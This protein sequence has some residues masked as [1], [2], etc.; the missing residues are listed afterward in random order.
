MFVSG[1]EAAAHSGRNQAQALELIDGYE[2]LRIHIG[3][4][5]REIRE[6]LDAARLE[7]AR[8]YLTGLDP[9][10]FERV[11][12]LTG[13]LGFERRDPRLAMERE[14]HVLSAT[15]ASIEADERYQQRELRVGADG[16]L[17]QKRIETTEMLQPWLDECQ[18]FEQHEGFLELIRVGY[19]TPGFSESWWQ[20]SYWKHWA[21]GDR[22]CK[23]LEMD[24][25]GDD[26]LPE[27]NKAAEQ[28][29]FWQSELD[30]IDRQI[31][32]IHDLVQRRDGAVARIPRLPELYLDQ[33]QQQLGEYLEEADLSLLEDWLRERAA[34]DHPIQAGLRKL[35]GLKAK[36]SFLAELVNQGLN[37]SIGQLRGRAQK[38][39]RK[40][41]K[42][43]RPKNYSRRFGDR[44]LDAK[45][46]AKAAKYQQRQAKLRSMVNRIYAYDDY[47]RFSLANDPALWWMEITGRQPPRLMPHTWRWYQRH[48]NLAPNLDPIDDDDDTLAHGVAVAAAA[49]DLDEVGYLS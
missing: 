23:A 34:G 12:Q 20:A 10:A 48:P 7:L 19:D 44:D 41:Q 26:V 39:Q 46:A 37:D 36:D 9:E 35:S 13:F 25:F 21:A 49:R 11:K 47:D 6:Q 31:Q 4:R 24:D 38:Y 1:Q 5:R 29:G 2:K 15:V 8:A 17:T 33:C 28:R 14:Q 40:V 45:F 27:Y 32:I 42:F 30:G 3:Q 22:I 16:T 18:K 43:L